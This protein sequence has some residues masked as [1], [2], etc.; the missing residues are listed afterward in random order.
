MHAFSWLVALTLRSTVVL[1]VALAL[2]LLLRRSSAVARHRLSTLTAVSVLALPA[3]PLVLPSFALPLAL[4]IP[5]PSSLARVGDSATP[6][7]D[8]VV[9]VEHGRPESASVDVDA[10]VRDDV[11]T[12]R[13]IDSMTAF[14]VAVVA[15]WSIGVAVG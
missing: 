2:G 5:G 14:A 6:A 11:P 13:S 12:S 1:S 10:A 9:V 7:Q 15:A 3:L 4:P 8:V